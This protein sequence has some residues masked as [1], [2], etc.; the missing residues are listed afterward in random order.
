MVVRLRE[1]KAA[2]D[3][4]QKMNGQGEQTEQKDEWNKDK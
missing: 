1:N 4:I 3:R 2:E